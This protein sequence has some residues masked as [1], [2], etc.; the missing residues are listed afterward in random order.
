MK[1]ANALTIV[2]CLLGMT[3]VASASS[4]REAPAIAEDQYADNT[5][6]YAFIAPE[7]PSRVVFIANYVPLLSPASGPNFYK[8]SD[9]VRYEIRIDN[10]GDAVAD[11][12]Y[13]FRFRTT[14]RNGMT[15]LYNTGAVD[16]VDDMDLNVRQTYEVRRKNL[17]TGM[18]TAIGRDLPVAPWDVGRRSFPNYDSV[19]SMAVRNAMTAR[20][21][22]G[23]RR[24]AFQVDF[25]VFDLLGLGPRAAEAMPALTPNY[26]SD[27]NVMSLV[28]SVPIAE[29][30]SGGVQPATTTDPTS[31][32]GV[33]AVATRRAVSVL[34]QSASDYQFGTYIQ[35]SRLG[36]PLVNEVLVPLANKN[37]FNKSNPADDAANYGATIL[38]PELNGLLRGVIPELGCTPTPETGNATILAILTPNGTAPG[39]LLR[40]NV[41][42]G[43][44][45]AHSAFPNGRTL[46]DDVLTAEVNVVCTG[47]PAMPLPPDVI[48]GPEVEG[49]TDTFPY[50]PSPIRSD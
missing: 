3:S 14:T 23:P 26:A 21:F 16:S 13:E 39:D 1:L 24:E 38:N 28:L 29:V 6:V 48:G 22:A 18:V 11:I 36:I 34:R 15:F 9:N 37:N 30:A 50:M 44:T 33:Y 2:F 47:N 25:N 7:D 43:Q 20:V 12:A 32:L 45:F 8:F 46:R 4:H 41:G 17:D 5:D 31:L 42:A 10:D 40:L 19:A 49:I 27:Y 35:V